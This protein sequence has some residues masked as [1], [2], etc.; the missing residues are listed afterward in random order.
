MENTT[1]HTPGPWMQHPYGWQMICQDKGND[2]IGPGIAQALNHAGLSL[3]AAQANAILMTTSPELLEALEDCVQYIT[4]NLTATCHVEYSGVN[5]SEVWLAKNKTLQ[6]ANAV[7]KK[8][9]GE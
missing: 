2:M 7:I 3:E 1:K 5:L 6:K 8:A 9:K 4:A